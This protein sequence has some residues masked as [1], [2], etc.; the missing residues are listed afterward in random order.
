MPLVLKKVWILFVIA[1]ILAPCLVEAFDFSEAEVLPK[2]VDSF[3]L[4]RELLVEQSHQLVKMPVV[5]FYCFLDGVKGSNK[6]FASPIAE[7]F[8]DTPAFRDGL[9]DVNK[10]VNARSNEAPYNCGKYD[11]VIHVVG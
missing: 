8:S 6:F 1:M 4:L 7:I 2:F 11:W 5:G 10:D 3:P 9:P